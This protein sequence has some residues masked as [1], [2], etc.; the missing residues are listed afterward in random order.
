MLG[1][2]ASLRTPHGESSGFRVRPPEIRGHLRFWWRAIAGAQQAADPVHLRQLE[3]SL[4]GAASRAGRVSLHITIENPGRT[5]TRQEQQELPAPTPIYPIQN[6][7]RPKV[8]V[9]VHF[10]VTLQLTPSPGQSSEA[11]ESERR[12]LR[13]AAFAWTLFGGLGCRSRRGMGAILCT[14]FAHPNYQLSF[15][16]GVPGQTTPRFTMPVWSDLLPDYSR[17]WSHLWSKPLLAP[18]SSRSNTPLAAM[19]ELI[20]DLRTY[21][22]AGGCSEFAS[23]D[24]LYRWPNGARRWPSGL[25]LRPVRIGTHWFKMAVPLRMQTS[26]LDDSRRTYIEGIEHALDHFW[27]ERGYR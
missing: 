21:R 25:L 2:G 22:Q 19:N 4:W 23:H 13:R 15:P 17:P 10:T 26:V 8:I 24:R 11:F 20:E 6:A 1:G 9:D 14:S 18:T 16:P 12:D 3:A 27:D 5:L 7:D